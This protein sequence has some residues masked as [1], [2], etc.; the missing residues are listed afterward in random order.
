MH[1]RLELLPRAPGPT[2]AEL[3]FVDD[4][5]DSPQVV[6]VSGTAVD[7]PSSQPAPP[8]P[9][10][11]A[12]LS[13]HPA[14]RTKSRIATFTFSGNST[15]A[16][17]VCRLDRGPFRP[18]TSPTKYRSLK[19][20]QHQFTVRATSSGGTQ[21]QG[22]NFSWQIIAKRAHKKHPRHAAAR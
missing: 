16:G 8:P 2:S 14:K 5:L 22:A 13:G 7:A 1:L 21:T 6:Q 10:P 19:L 15:A 9:T 18:C 20:G 11:S 17:F 4:A 12:A 3:R